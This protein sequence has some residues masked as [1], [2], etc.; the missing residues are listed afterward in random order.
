MNKTELMM[1][2]SGFDYDKLLEERNKRAQLEEEKVNRIVSELLEIYAK[3]EKLN[4]FLYTDS[5]VYLRF[6]Y[7]NPITCRALHKIFMLAAKA[8]DIETKQ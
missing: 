5:I 2:Q 6:K 4:S 8:Q 1:K 7:A 3:P